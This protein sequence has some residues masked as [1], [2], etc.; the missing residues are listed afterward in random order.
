MLKSWIKLKEELFIKKDLWLKVLKRTFKLPNGQVGDFFIKQEGPAVCILALTA[1]Q[2]IILVKQFR[3][4]PE[5]SLLELPGGGIN[6]GEAPEVAAQREF[7]EETG[8]TGDFQFVGTSLDCAYSTMIRYNFAATQCHK[9]QEQQLDAT[10]FIEIIE[11][12]LGNFRRHLRS[13]KLT[14]IETAYL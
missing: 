12:P 11:M 1:E 5:E 14:D 2:K 9:A 4:G 7:L 8:Y 10:E 6:E 3:P 13:G